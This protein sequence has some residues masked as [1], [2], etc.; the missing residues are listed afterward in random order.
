MRLLLTI[1]LIVTTSYLHAFELKFF[2]TKKTVLTFNADSEAYSQGLNEFY[3]IVSDYKLSGNNIGV[4]WGTKMI[5]GYKTNSS[6]ELEKF[7]IVNFIKGSQYQ[8]KLVRGKVIREDVYARQS[9]DKIIN[10]NHDK[11]MIDSV[12]RDPM[13]WSSPENV[14]RHYTYKWNK[15]KDSHLKESSSIFGKLKP[16]SNVTNLYITDRPGTAF[17]EVGSGAKNIDLEFETCIYYAKDIPIETTPEEMDFASPLKCITWDSL[18]IY[19][20]KTNRYEMNK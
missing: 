4:H 8:T 3:L 12:D 11:W 6:Q 20:F 18:F 14:S 9:F 1:F 17:Y 15:V 10:F 13:Y 2:N 16:S 7:A 19:N 5:A